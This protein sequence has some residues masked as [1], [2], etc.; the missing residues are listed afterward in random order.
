M[1]MD[2]KTRTVNSIT[3]LDLNGRFDSYTAPA[4]SN[5][6]DETATAGAKILI[7]LAEV[8]FIDSSA[9]AVLIKGLK[10]SRQQQGDLVLCSLQSPVRVIF[11]LTRLDKAF[12]IYATENEALA[13]LQ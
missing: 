6:V 5:W 12:N 2:F 3:I 11:E 13:A 4:I 10:R 1:K 7:N 8:S 9:L